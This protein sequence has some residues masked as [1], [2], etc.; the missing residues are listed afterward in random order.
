VVSTTNSVLGSGAVCCLFCLVDRASRS[1]LV[2]HTNTMQY[3]FTSFRY[4][5]STCFGLICSPS[6]GGQV[7]NVAMVLLLLLQR[8]SAGLESNNSTIATLY[9]WPP[10][11]EL[12]MSP[13]HVEVW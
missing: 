10:D 7:Y 12:Q 8:L 1:I 13:K 6:S 5:T 9:T 3:F 2:Q 4:H 11:D